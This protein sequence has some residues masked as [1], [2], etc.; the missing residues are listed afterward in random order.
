MQYEPFL[1]PS[2]NRSRVIHR[3]CVSIRSPLLLLRVNCG[4]HRSFSADSLTS[5]SR[6]GESASRDTRT[7]TFSVGRYRL[8]LLISSAISA[9]Y[10]T[11]SYSV[12]GPFSEVYTPLPIRECRLLVEGVI[13]YDPSRPSSGSVEFNR[14]AARFSIAGGE[15]EE[16]RPSDRSGSYLLFPNVWFGIYEHKAILD[17]RRGRS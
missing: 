5:S 10:F 12:G 8:S 15:H 16:T 17:P 14:S 7:S 1:P 11:D 6:T 9:G 2:R 3:H 13:G 4:W